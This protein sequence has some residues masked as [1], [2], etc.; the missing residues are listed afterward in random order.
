[1]AL[2]SPI[3]EVWYKVKLSKPSLSIT[4]LC[5]CGNVIVSAYTTFGIVLLVPL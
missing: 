5:V 4:N 1:M 2:S 3:P